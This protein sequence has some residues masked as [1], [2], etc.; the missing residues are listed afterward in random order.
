MNTNTPYIFT[1]PCCGKNELHQFDRSIVRYKVGLI[2]SIKDIPAAGKHEHID[3]EQEICLG[4]RCGHCLYP[5]KS[6]SLAF[7]WKSIE[8][9]FKADAIAP[10]P[11]YSK[12]V[13]PCLICASNGNNIPLLLVLNNG[14]PIDHNLKKEIISR[15]LN[16][17]E[18]E[19]K[20]FVLTNEDFV[21]LANAN[22]N[23]NIPPSHNKR[24]FDLSD[25][26]E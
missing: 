12:K 25:Y 22:I 4:Y 23:E 2:S 8:D 3:Y 24:I 14:Q 16:F 9:A 11:L 7:Q 10:N 17:N 19:T 15:T 21:F 13:V 1:C 20:T 18:L 5:D 6:D 26:S